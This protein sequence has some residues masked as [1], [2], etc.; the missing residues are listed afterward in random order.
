MR[1]NSNFSMTYSSGGLG[2]SARF[3]QLQLVC[4]RGARIRIRPTRAALRVSDTLKILWK[5]MFYNLPLASCQ[6]IPRTLIPMLQL[7]NN[8]YGISNSRLYP[9]YFPVNSYA[10][11]LSKFP[12]KNIEHSSTQWLIYI[13]NGGTPQHNPPKTEWTI[14]SRSDLYWTFLIVGGREG[15]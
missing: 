11:N 15:V 6:S 14:Q 8:L 12:K 3:R 10:N 9:H 13:Y 7:T 5:I 4:A 1:P 2:I